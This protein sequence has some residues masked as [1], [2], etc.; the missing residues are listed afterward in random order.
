MKIIKSTLIHGTPFVEFIQTVYENKI[1]NRSLWHWTRRTE[2]TKAVMIAAHSF[3]GKGQ[4][5][6]AVTKEFR[7]PLE[8]YEWGFPSGLIDK[9]ESPEETARREFY[10]E[11]GL[12]ITNFI[13]PV[14]PCV[15]NSP[16]ITNEG[17]H[18]AFAY[19]NGEIDT[20]NNES[21]ED[22]HVYLMTMKEV[23]DLIEDKTKKI[24]AKAYLIM[25]NFAKYGYL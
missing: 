19:F 11:T 15:Y 9:F 16:G 13:G 6:L 14:S 3:N 20:S 25:R 24:G 17:I 2:D 4:A 7:V 12:N 1:G 21:S 18:I 22:I 23:R 8:D 5:I 10:E